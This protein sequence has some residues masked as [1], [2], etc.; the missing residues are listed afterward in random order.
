MEWSPKSEDRKP[1]QVKEKK[2]VLQSWAC[3]ILTRK[4]DR[5][6]SY[7]NI[8]SIFDQLAEKK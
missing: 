5:K 2:V 1:E 6:N 4:L 8:E 7:K 3:K